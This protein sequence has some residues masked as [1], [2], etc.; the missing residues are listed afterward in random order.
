MEVS[1]TFAS[2]FLPGK[3]V[4]MAQQRKLA[5]IMFTDILGYT[6]LMSKDEHKALQTLKKNREIQKPLIEKYNGE[7][8]KEMGDGTLSCFPSVVDAVNCALE[9]QNSLK[10]DSDLILRIGIHM[11][12]IVFAEGDIFGDGVNIASRIEPLA[13]PGGICITGRVYNDIRNKPDIGTVFLGEKKLKNVSRPI[14][15]YALTGKDLP[16]PPIEKTAILDTP[17]DRKAGTSISHY[18]ILGKIG[19]GGMGVVYKAEDTKLKRTVALKFLRTEIVGS[20][21]QKARFFKEAQ[22]AAS[23]NHPNI[24]TIYEIDEVEGRI[25]IA[26]EFVEGQDLLEK[27]E[28]GPINI[29]EALKFAIQIGEGLTEAHE[30]GI[31]HRDIKSANIMVTKN[32]Q[33]K[34]M[35]FG[36]AKTARDTMVTK[37]GTT[38]GTVAYMSPEQGRGETVDHRADIWSLGVIMYE[39]LAGQ[40]PFKGEYETALVYLILNE[41]PEPLKDVPADIESIVNRMLAKK[42]DDRYQSAGELVKDLSK[43]RSRLLKPEIGLE[44]EKK[45]L[46]KI[47]RPKVAIPSIVIILLISFVLGW[48]INRSAKVRWARDQAIP[49]LMRLVEEIDYI[50]YLDRTVAY[51]LAME[52]EK[53][54]PSDSVLIMLLGHLTRYVTIESEPPGANVYDKEYPA[55]NADWEYLGQTPFDSIR[56]PRGFFRFKFEKKGYQDVYTTAGI[57]GPKIF[58]KLDEEGKIPEDMIRVPGGKSSPVLVG[59]EHLE[60]VQIDDYLLDKYEVTNKAFKQFLDSG[61]YE[62]RKYWKHPIVKEGQTLS[63]EEALAEFKDKTGR[64]GPATWEAGDYPDGQEEYPVSGIGWYEAAAYAE[65]A[66]K[67]LPTVY[68]WARAARTG[69]SAFI[70]PLSN[71]K[72]RGPA[73]VGSYEGMNAYGTFD[74]AGNVREW[75]WNESGQ[76][77]RFILGGGWNDATYQFNAAFA[78]LPFSRY[79]TNGFRCMKYL[80]K[81]ENLTVLKRP[82]E[83]AYRDFMKEKPVSDEVYQIYLSMYAYDKTELNTVVESIDSSSEDCIEEKISFDAA[84]GGERVTAYLFIPKNVDPP[85]Q[86][87][88]YF[89]GSGAIHTGTSNISRSWRTAHID[90]LLK[91]GR[92]FIY[93]V[94]KSCFER[95]DAL[96]S[97]MP[98]ETN[99]YKEHVIQ[100]AKDLGRSIDYL[101]TRKDIDTDKLAYYGM[102]WGGRMGGIMCAVEN[103]LKASVLHVAGLKFQTSL[104]EVD[105]VNF[106][107]RIKIP[108]L[109]LNGRYDHYFPVETSQIPMFELLGTPAEHKR[110]FIY[111]T[112]HFVPRTQLIKEFL[113]WLDKYLGPVK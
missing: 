8:L 19:E 54:I 71:F 41:D 34:I 9:I 28:S 84:Y 97:D 101:E 43:Y 74:M 25:F 47:K 46:Q 48:F 20:A 82:I 15:V 24:G 16:T 75:C 18:R 93:P 62:K 95:R 91:S 44:Q 21:E 98:N 2:R 63:W 80:G 112:G 4:H 11:G 111:E 49:E 26:M 92:A 89:P 7:W 65:F 108:V 113:D 37:E 30:K 3:L 52:A 58:R 77:E 57:W 106:L 99:F 87:I 36:L 51:E 66:G 68:H 17:V 69:T 45:F 102:S 86:T 83:R 76:N 90:F 31:V 10:S 64:P 85:Y 81:D 35:D 59:L 61:G 1:H 104:P 94:Y 72:D 55:I 53:Y 42:P 22:A 96:I 56:V 100:W 78:Q 38:L 50:D 32:G 73:P 67:S 107:P 23:L 105:P 14:K 12:D 103:R 79:P 70:V 13:Q 88:V 109:M 40:R 29:E 33:A 5:A 110:L 6:A 27:I 60:A 39:M